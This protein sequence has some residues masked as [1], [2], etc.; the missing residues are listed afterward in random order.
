MR[1]IINLLLLALV[2]FLIF[3]LVQSISEPIAFKAEKDK[4]EN[5]VIDKLMQVRQAQE[6][7]RSIH[8][9]SFAGSWEDLKTTLKTGRI[10]YVSVIGDPDDPNFTGEITYDTTFIE[11]RDS[12]R[13]LGWNVDSLQY[14]PYGGG[15]SFEIKADTLSYQKTL[16]NVVEVG[17]S[18]KTF[19]GKY[20]DAAFRRYDASYQPGSF[21]K[22]GDMN[23]PNLSGNWER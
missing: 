6:I 12:V 10:P 15:K 3:L 1:L 23:K 4:R 9:G 19:M 21:I 2:A 7:Y 22:F 20:A 16:V 18:R 11:A 8:D 17:T 13:S 14:I 5:A